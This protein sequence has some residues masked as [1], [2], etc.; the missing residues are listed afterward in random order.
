MS[1]FKIFFLFGYS[2]NHKADNPTKIV[3]KI[4]LLSKAI[5]LAIIAAYIF[6][7]DPSNAEPFSSTNIEAAMIADNAAVGANRKYSSR[8]FGTFKNLKPE[9][10]ENLAAKFARPDAI[11]TSQ[12]ILM[13]SCLY[14]LQQPFR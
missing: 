11:I 10:I 7:A 1:T 12:I 4:D 3:N 8:D 9:N 6:V 2:N 5:Q 13:S 14:N